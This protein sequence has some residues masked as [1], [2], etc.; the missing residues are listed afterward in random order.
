MSPKYEVS[1]VETKLKKF[2]SV[3]KWCDL[4]YHRLKK[5]KKAPCGSGAV[6]SAKGCGRRDLPSPGSLSSP[7]NRQAALARALPGTSSARRF[8]PK[9]KSAA[10]RKS[11]ASASSSRPCPKPSPSELEAEGKQLRQEGFALAAEWGGR[12]GESGL[13]RGSAAARSG[14]GHSAEPSPRSAGSSCPRCPQFALRGPGRGGGWGRGA[15]PGAPRS[16]ALTGTGEA[17]VP[18]RRALY[19]SRPEDRRPPRQLRQRLRVP[20][21]GGGAEVHA[22]RGGQAVDAGQPAQ[23]VAGGA[24]GPPQ[25][26][27][28]A[29]RR[30][31]GQLRVEAAQ[32]RRLEAGGVLQGV[33]EERAL[34]LGHVVQRGQR[35]AAQHERTLPVSIHLPHR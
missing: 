14:T 27:A 33:G 28:D 18:P 29:V 11:G 2:Y 24:H 23:Q 1:Y 15:P 9:Q 3:S 5:K 35:R 8:S 25:D 19:H 22:G 21:Y 34:H 30:P 16:V 4:N 32:G 12:G 10:P 20:G 6:L 13:S 7:A 17:R 26:V 31:Q